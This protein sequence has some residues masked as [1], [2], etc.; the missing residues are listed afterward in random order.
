MTLRMGIKQNEKCI[1]YD[2]A[3]SIHN[4]HDVICDNIWYGRLAPA[5]KNIH[6]YPRVE[7]VNF[8]LR[9]VFQ[10]S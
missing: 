10:T 8:S 6:V 7:D 1:L 9:I 3:F 4:V 5:A 2:T